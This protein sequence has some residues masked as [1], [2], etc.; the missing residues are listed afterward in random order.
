MFSERTR[1]LLRRLKLGALTLAV[2]LVLAAVSGAAYQSLAG[3]LDLAKYPPPGQLVDIG[4]RSL[5]LW[6]T[7]EGSPT[8]LLEAGLSMGVAAWQ[9]VQAAVSRLT[10]VCSY[11]RAG[12]GWSDEGPAP[13]TSRAISDDLTRLL[14]RA[15]IT[16]PLIL[17]GHSLGGLYLRHFAAL[18]LGTVS[19]MV[20]V[21]SSHEDQGNPGA[22]M[23][24]FFL[25]ANAMGTRRLFMRFDHP[26]FDSVYNA[27][28]N[29]ATT[30]RE[31]EG[32]AASARDV[33]AASLSLGDRPLVV[34]SRDSP[35]D[36]SWSRLQLDLLARS[37][38]SKRIVVEGAGHMIHEERPEAVVAAIQE[39]VSDSRRQPIPAQAV[40]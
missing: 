12:Y 28:K 32:V 7:G 22:V 31:L 36:S 3:R 1:R 34:L 21:D 25:I 39:L 35:P 5:H 9:Q 24:G 14:D 19:G 30:Q 4:G 18:H 40:P 16:P 13:R 38:R 37:Q 8:V 33:K 6:C 17:V 10:R 23:Q 27:N 26:V 2:L 15:Q 11:D 20:L 29:L